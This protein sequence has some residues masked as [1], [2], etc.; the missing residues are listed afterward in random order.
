MRKR[1]GIRDK[2]NFKVIVKRLLYM[3][4]LTGAVVILAAAGLLLFVGKP[5][6]VLT[7]AALGLGLLLFFGR[8]YMR[9][10]VDPV[11]GLLD[12]ARSALQNEYRAENMRVQAEMHALQ[13]QINPH[14]LYNTLE[15]IRGI[16]MMKGAD[17]IAEITESLSA[18]FRYSISN[19]GEMA[20][21]REELENVRSYLRIQQYRFPNKVYYSEEIADPEILNYRIP[22]LTIQPIIENAISHGLEKKVGMGWVKF[23]AV[24]TNYHIV[25]R[26]SDN[27]IGMDEQRLLELRTSLM[28]GEEIKE[29]GHGKSKDS[30]IAL[31]NVNQRL[32][33]YYGEPYGLNVMSTRNVGTTVEVTLPINENRS[34]KS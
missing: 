22:I 25:M 2:D 11:C 23:Q 1:A 20:S 5:A 21:L 15:T 32:K 9:K 16:A 13:S 30:G 26:I 14:F 4:F 33:F 34:I 3:N 27:G 18:L 31:R 12:T 29:N 28:S 10:M 17:E 6:A 8:L 7:I 24:M 19:P